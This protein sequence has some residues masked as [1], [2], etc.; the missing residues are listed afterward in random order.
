MK[1]GPR[2]ILIALILAFIGIAVAFR[3]RAAKRLV[4]GIETVIGCAPSAANLQTDENGK[5]INPLPG[6]GQNVLLNWCGDTA[7]SMASLTPVSSELRGR[8]SAFID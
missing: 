5:F 2:I 4:P 3:P 8:R 1:Y 6:L 7:R